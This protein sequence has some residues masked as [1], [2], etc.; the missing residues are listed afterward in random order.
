MNRPDFAQTD[1]SRLG[2]RDLQ[3][4]IE[5]MPGAGGSYEEIARLL[6]EMPS[7]VESMLNSDYVWE[8]IQARQQ[9]ILEISPFLFFNVL[10]RRSLGRPG[11]PLERRVTNY[12]ANLLTL[13]IHTGRVYRAEAGEEPTEYVTGLLQTAQESADPRRAFITYAHIGNYTL[14]LTGLQA[15]WLEYRHRFGRRPVSPDYYREF[16][17]SYFDRAARHRLASEFA[18]EDVFRR[19]AVNFEFYRAGLDHMWRSRPQ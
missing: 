12:I 10:L 14:W 15:A 5:Q 6:H 11:G 9:T 4:L 17:Q 7:T 18:L 16:G 13:F 3:F 8:L 1:L 19:L 2:N